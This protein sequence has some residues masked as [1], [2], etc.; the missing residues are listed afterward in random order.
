MSFVKIFNFPLC[1]VERSS[2][3]CGLGGFFNV[4]APCSAR[5]ETCDPSDTRGSYQAIRAI[6]ITAFERLEQDGSKRSSTALNLN[7]TQTPVRIIFTH[8]PSLHVFCIFEGGFQFRR[9]G[10]IGMITFGNAGFFGV[11]NTPFIIA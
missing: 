6:R 3:L 7:P 1:E 4:T 5:Y 2:T 9:R 11:K 8:P 10:K